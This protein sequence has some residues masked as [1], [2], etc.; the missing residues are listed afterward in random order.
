MIYHS[1]NII[2]QK[3]LKL[4]RQVIPNQNIVQKK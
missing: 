2:L 3:N 4:M 1:K